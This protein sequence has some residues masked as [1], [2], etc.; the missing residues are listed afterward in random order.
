MSATWSLP[1]W[2]TISGRM[3]DFRKR[4]EEATIP[5]LANMMMQRSTSYVCVGLT[6]TARDSRCDLEGANVQKSFS[7][8]ER[9]QRIL[10]P[11]MT[12][13]TIAL[14]LGHTQFVAFTGPILKAH[15][16]G[17]LSASVLKHIGKS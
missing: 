17:F 11:K 10:H 14:S 4:R 13:C 16:S 3:K 1:S 12:N 9:N 15:K 8:F 5:S 7:K 6:R 2:T